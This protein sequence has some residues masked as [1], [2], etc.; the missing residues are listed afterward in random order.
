MSFSSLFALPPSV[1]VLH[2]TPLFQRCP[3]LMEIEA[4]KNCADTVPSPCLPLSK[5]LLTP[6]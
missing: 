2:V 3:S 1:R 4:G 6:L 5:S